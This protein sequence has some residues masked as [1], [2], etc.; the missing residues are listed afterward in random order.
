MTDHYSPRFQNKEKEPFPRRILRR[1]MILFERPRVDLT[2]AQR[3]L[4]DGVHLA[5][6]TPRRMAYNRCL[7]HAS[8]LAYQTLLAVVPVLALSLAVLSNGAFEGPRTAFLDKVVDALY[9]LQ[10]QTWAMDAPSDRAALE[11]LNRQGKNLVRS[12][13]DRFAH[14]AA[15]VGTAGFL[16]LL[17]VVVFLFRN[18]ETSFNLLWGVEKGRRWGAQTVR[19][20]LFLVGVPLLVWT[21]LLLK[22]L[23]TYLPV[24]KPGSG[25]FASFLWGTLYPYLAVVAALTVLYRWVPRAEVNPRSA[26]QAA[27]VAALVLEAFRHLFTFYA[28]RIL[29]V[30]R[31]Y[32]ALAVVPLVMV[33]LYLSWAVVLFGAEVAHVL[34][35]LDQESPQP[36]GNNGT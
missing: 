33:W 16:G 24:L 36:P 18:I 29:N 26:R 27:C 1:V 3:F 20:V 28:V 13:I 6:R 7:F 8:A 12:S 19:A 35:H 11:K 9:P 15:R 23:L 2:R 30:S 17:M 5:Q 25:A 34:Q 4:V 14:G 32:G 31:V 21:A 22:T 10:S